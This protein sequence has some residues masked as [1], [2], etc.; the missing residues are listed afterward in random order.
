[1]TL[2][3]SVFIM[4]PNV[5]S[6]NGLHLLFKLGVPIAL[7]TLAQMII[8]S[9]NDLDLSMGSF[10]SFVACVTATWLVDAPLIGASDPARGDR[11]HTACWAW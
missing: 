2:L 10:V 3:I 4:R 6:Y 9:V 5:M 7:A 8:M 1:M 11:D